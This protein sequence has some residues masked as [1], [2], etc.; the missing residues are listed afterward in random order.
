MS[1][2]VP[3]GIVA[4][5]YLVWNGSAWVARGQDGVALGAGSVGSTA[6][7]TALGSVAVANGSNTVSLGNSSTTNG[8][9]SIAIGQQSFADSGSVAIGYQTYIDSPGLGIDIASSVAL[10]QQIQMSCAGIMIGAKITTLAPPSTKQVVLNGSTLPLTTGVQSGFFVDPV[11]NDVPPNE[12]DFRMYY[13]VGTKEITYGAAS[14]VE[15]L[16]GVSGTSV[17]LPPRAVAMPAGSETPCVLSF[18]LLNPLWAKYGDAATYSGS[19]SLG[20]VLT[21]NAVGQTPGA[22]VLW[23]VSPSSVAGSNVG[24]SL[25]S[26]ANVD[27]SAAPN[28]PYRINVPGGG[29]G[30]T[31]PV[32]YLS[33]PFTINPAL[34]GTGQ[35]FYLNAVPDLADR[36]TNILVSCPYAQISVQP[37]SPVNIQS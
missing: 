36:A 12:Q 26:P 37:A 11:R 13:N 14:T 33:I 18:Q 7:N 5:Q 10:G 19:V 15:V 35:Y 31:L 30:S 9:G 6:K 29:F 8:A 22:D 32:Q 34:D 17:V 27:P 2:P 24:G 1:V 28:A 21:V 4:G 16:E 3:P 23:S 25:G 20:L